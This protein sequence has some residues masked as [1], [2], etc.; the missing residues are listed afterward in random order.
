MKIAELDT[1]INQVLEQE[2][3][4]LIMEQISDT[5]HIIDAVKNLQT[6]SPLL[7]KISNIEDIGNGNF[8]ILISVDNI[9]PEELVNCCGGSSLGEAERNLMQGL[10][11]DL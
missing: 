10:H 1:M 8:G 6:L 2:A 4:K 3:K 5:D 9:T 11:H 7:G